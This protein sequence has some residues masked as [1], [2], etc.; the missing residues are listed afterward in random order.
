[1]GLDRRGL[2]PS[3]HKRSKLRHSQSSDISVEEIRESGSSFQSLIV[4]GKNY[5]NRHLYLL[6]V[7]EMPRS[8]DSYL[9]ESTKYLGVTITMD[10]KWNTHIGNV[11]TK[12]LANRTLVFR[13]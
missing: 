3:S 5:V 2:A 7:S 6:K 13:F 1:M 10:I 12:G 4:W 8:V 9:P 11:C